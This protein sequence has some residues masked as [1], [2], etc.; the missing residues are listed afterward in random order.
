MA[1]EAHAVASDAAPWGWNG[2]DIGCKR[3]FY[4]HL[5]AVGVGNRADPCPAW[6]GERA[7]GG[8]AWRLECVLSMPYLVTLYMDGLLPDRLQPSLEKLNLA[9]RAEG[10]LPLDL[11]LPIQVEELY[12]AEPLLTESHVQSIS[13]MTGLREFSLIDRKG[14]YF[15]ILWPLL[16]GGSIRC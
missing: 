7:N 13:S 5:H 12:L 2:A 16:E 3:A 11:G 10:E 6:H 1:P 14:E 15:D 9:Q 8:R 4:P